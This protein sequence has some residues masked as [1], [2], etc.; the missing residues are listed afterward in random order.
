ML[1]RTFFNPERNNYVEFKDMLGMQYR[2]IKRF[3]EVFE[4]VVD[5][6]NIKELYIK[7]FFSENGFNEKFTLYIFTENAVIEINPNETNDYESAFLKYSNIE[8]LNF[9][10]NDTGNCLDITF[11]NGKLITLK[12][13]ADTNREWKEEYDDLIIAIT[14]FLYGKLK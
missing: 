11:S 7:D 2:V 10:K 9:Q 8:A 14:Q 5:I 1:Y 3:L 13:D 6:G 12:S 4:K